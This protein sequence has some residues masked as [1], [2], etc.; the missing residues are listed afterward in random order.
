L[1][2][3]LQDAEEGEWFDSYIHYFQEHNIV[4]TNWS[5]VGYYLDR[6]EAFEVLDRV[7]SFSEV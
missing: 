2:F 4:D 6:K 5:F 1:F 7:L 3:R